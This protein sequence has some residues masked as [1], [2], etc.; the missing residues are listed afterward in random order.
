MFSHFF[1]YENTVV[2]QFYGHT[3]KDEFFVVYDEATTSRTVNFGFVSPSATTWT[4]YYP[5]FRIFTMD[6]PYIG[7]SMVGIVPYQSS[8]IKDNNSCKNIYD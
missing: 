5:S 4:E 7:G 3:H 8:T 2:N 1:R 6:G